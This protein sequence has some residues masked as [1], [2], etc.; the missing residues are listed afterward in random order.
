MNKFIAVF[1]CFLALISLSS[2]SLGATISIGSG[3][4]NFTPYGTTNEWANLPTG[5]NNNYSPNVPSDSS[6]FPLNGIYQSFQFSINGTPNSTVTNVQIGFHFS[7]LFDD[8]LALGINNSGNVNYVL[9]QNNYYGPSYNVGGGVMR[10]VAPWTNAIDTANMGVVINITSTGTL[11]NSYVYGTSVSGTYVNTF[12]NLTNGITLNSLGLGSLDSSG[13][14][15]ATSRLN[16][17]F[18]N[19][20]GWGGGT[21][22]LNT[23]SF[24]YSVSTIYTTAIAEAVP[25]PS[26]YALF[27]LGAFG[28]LMAIRRKK[29]A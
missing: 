10:T 7:G 3:N 22:T 2:K 8:S 23:N 21:P 4:L 9:T 15:T 26:T 12:D 1:T 14:A 13:S 24:N 20:I 19:Q 16:V 28:M 11:V 25:E 27:G 17:G 6:K 5:F 29:T 18:L